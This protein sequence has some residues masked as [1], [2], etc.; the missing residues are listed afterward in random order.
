V[1]VRVSTYHDVGRRSVEGD[2]VSPSLWRAG[3][4]EPRHC[5]LEDEAWREGESF[6]GVRKA[7]LDGVGVS[8]ARPWAYPLP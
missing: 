3:L 7:A 8:G 1:A 5:C 4:W 6:V 2:R